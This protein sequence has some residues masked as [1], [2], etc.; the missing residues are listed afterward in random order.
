MVGSVSAS[1]RAAVGAAYD[2]VAPA[3]ASTADPLVYRH[4]AAPLATAVAGALAASPAEGPGRVLDVA[5]GA[6]ALGRALGALPAG[7]RPRSQVVAVDLAGGA[8]RHNPA[9]LRAQADAAALPFAGDAFAVAASAFGI[10][11]VATPALV[12]GEMARVAPVV[13]LSTWSRS[14][15]PYLPREVVDTALADQVGTSRSALGGTLDTL[16]DAVGTPAALATLLEA[17]GLDA[18]AEAVEVAIP[19]PGVEAYVAYRLA[20]PTTARAADERALVDRARA[21]LAGA[22]PEALT[23][24]A[25]VVVA[26]GRRV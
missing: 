1:A 26:V 15:A 7:A 21:A 22:S 25:S 2:Q 18:R 12:V 16:A 5:A 6:G 3:Y 24:R 11:H 14:G 17:A 9:G 20:M 8:L 10:N 4:L 23:W 13:A 19:W